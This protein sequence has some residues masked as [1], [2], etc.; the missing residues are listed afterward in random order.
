MESQLSDER[1]SDHAANL[2][3]LGGQL[4]PMRQSE[5]LLTAYLGRLSRT[6]QILRRLRAPQRYR[7]QDAKSVDLTCINTS[8]EEGEITQ[9][10]MLTFQMLESLFKSIK[11]H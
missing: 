11:S 1:V 2:S 8:E 10:R 5:M 9:A 3:Q 7:P 4:L 6:G